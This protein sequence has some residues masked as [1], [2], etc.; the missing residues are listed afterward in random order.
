MLG[1]RASSHG[2]ALRATLQLLSRRRTTP[3]SR[4]GTIT[5]DPQ[6][7][8]PVISVF[9]YDGDS[10]TQLDD[11]TPDQLP[12]LLTEDRVTWI[13]VDGLGD[14]S[15]IRKIGELFSIHR[16]ALEDIVNVH[17]RAKVEEFEDH[18]FI[19]ARMVSVDSH[20][21]SEQIS[22][23]TGRN[24]VVTFQER[25]GDCLEPVRRRLLRGIGRL[26]TAGA[27]YLAY[28]IIDAVID[29]YFPVLDACSEQLDELDND[30]SGLHPRDLQATIHRLRSELYVL[31]RAIW[32]HREM[33]N[34]LIRD[35]DSRFDPETIRHLRDCY[36]HTIQILDTVDTSREIAS[37]VRDFHFTQI[38]IRQNEVM[39]V[40]TIVASIFIPLSFVTGL[41]GMNF[42]SSASPYN[43][44]ELHWPY[45]YPAV[46]GVMATM[47]SAMLLIF[48]RRGWI[49]R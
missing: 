17:Q 27:D 11:V 29:G 22:L 19:V 33:V 21:Q 36:D 14:E 4:P 13:N 44:P 46:L 48:W 30:Q 10:C 25:V 28:T 39:K 31:R 49:A 26:R 41:Y 32:P 35:M 40:L 43:M 6:A 24:Y 37:D 9:Q 12:D 1:Q 15:V 42:D 34:S 7:P 38:S 5:V 45:G 2:Q 3:G 23:I 20:L 47:V 16:L 18:L 8:Q